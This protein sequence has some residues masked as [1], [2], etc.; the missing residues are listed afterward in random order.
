MHQNN[1]EKKI[2]KISQ[3]VPYYVSY[4]H[5]IHCTLIISMKKIQFVM[6]SMY[7]IGND[8]LFDHFQCHCKIHLKHYVNR[9]T[10]DHSTVQMQ[11]ET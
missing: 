2:F 7:A 9:E 8:W 3:N 11:A 10:K 6:I 4:D 1:A 5:N